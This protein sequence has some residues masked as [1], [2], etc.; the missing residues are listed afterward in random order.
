MRITWKPAAPSAPT[1]RAETATPSMPTANTPNAC[2]TGSLPTFANVH[3][4][5]GVHAIP[6]AHVQVIGVFA[7]KNPI[8]PY[9]GAGRPEAIYVIERLIDD[10]ARELGHDPVGLRRKNLIPASAMPY[11][12][13]F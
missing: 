8:A 2:G 7:N 10:A 5:V 4:S 6:T 11:K 1:T 13:P 9:R 3:T 12:N